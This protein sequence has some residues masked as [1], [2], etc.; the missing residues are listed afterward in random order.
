MAWTHQPAPKR[1]GSLNAIVV[2]G[3]LAVAA[4][5]G[6]PKFL[7]QQKYSAGLQAYE[8][9]D[10]DRA[11]DQFDQFLKSASGDDDRAANAKAKKAQCQAFQTAQSQAS[12]RKI[13]AAA[14]F[15]DRYSSNEL[16][17]ILQKQT[18]PLLKTNAVN[19][20]V[21]D[22][23]DLLT[24]TEILSKDAT[25]DFYQTC[26]QRYTNQQRFAKAAGVYEKFLDEFPDHP[27]IASV[28]TALIKALSADRST[29]GELPPPIAQG[30]TD[31][32]ST[33]VL[34]RNALNTKMR[35]IF[36]GATPRVEEIEPCKECQE[37]TQATIPKGCPTQGIEASYKLAP[38]AYDVTVKSIGRTVTPF[39]GN[40]GL[41]GG[42][43]Y[44]NCFFIVRSPS[45]Q[46]QQ[47]PTPQN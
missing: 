23:A 27:Q 12:D 3:V 7:H 35:I 47:D 22:R 4:G 41:N 39:K 44:S 40:W 5:V 20:S 15:I 29:A 24:K 46:R 16:A 19:S 17:K 33:S 26:G 30:T 45:S 6:I 8:N 42:T 11:I 18:I 25:P 36:N 32:G 10:C 14:T 31:D 28:K 38:G 9:A 21:C 2:I 43:Q 34:I 13:L 1:P 37:Y